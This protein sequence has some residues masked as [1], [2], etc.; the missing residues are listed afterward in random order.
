MIK[1]KP[2][3][4]NHFMKRG[5]QKEVFQLYG[6]GVVWGYAGDYNDE[7]N[8]CSC[9]GDNSYISCKSDSECLG[10]RYYTCRLE[11][12]ISHNNLHGKFN[13]VYSIW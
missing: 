12:S 6:H 10:K 1:N 8:T 13:I 5:K 7:G 4:H 3:S 9:I 2:Y 11:S